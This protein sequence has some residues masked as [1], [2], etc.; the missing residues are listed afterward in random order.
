[1][2]M[3]MYMSNSK[4]KIRGLMLFKKKINFPDGTQDRHLCLTSGRMAY[5]DMEHEI[6][7]YLES[8]EQSYFEATQALMYMKD[9][10]IRYG[11]FSDMS[12]LTS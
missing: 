9:P 7:D 1:M 6:K 4:K 10:L 11:Y 12:L 3:Y 2:L 8:M 5:R